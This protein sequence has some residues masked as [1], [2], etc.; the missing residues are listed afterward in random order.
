MR[1]F[2]TGFYSGCTHLHS[3]QQC[4]RI[5]FSPQSQ[6]HIC[7]FL[8]V[9]LFFIIAILVG[10]RWYFIGVLIFMSLIINNVGHHFMCLLAIYVSSSEKCLFRISAHF[11]NQFF[12][13][14]LLLSYMGPLYIL[15]ISSLSDVLFTNILSHSLSWFFHF[16]DSF[17]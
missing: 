4:T 16:V 17:L 7:Y 15:D 13:F 9:C 5:L 6:Q 11:R 2:H 10:V 14:F 12:F 8:F 1:H 3:Y